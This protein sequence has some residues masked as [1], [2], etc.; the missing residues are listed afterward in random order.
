MSSFLICSNI[1]N[2]Q[3]KFLVC[4][5]ILNLHVWPF[6][7]TVK[8]RPLYVAD[9]KKVALYIG[10]WALGS[11]CLSLFVDS[12][13][14]CLEHV[15]SS[16]TYVPTPWGV[17]S[18]RYDQYLGCAHAFRTWKNCGFVCKIACEN[19][20]FSSVFV[21]G[22]VYGEKRGEMDVFAGYM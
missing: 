22:D 21:S 12:F 9:S 5:N 3:V 14:K 6:W 1:F 11:P 16:E 17:W 13:V 8:R 19:I 2:L 20:R 18:Y 7:A 4:S 10:N 15:E